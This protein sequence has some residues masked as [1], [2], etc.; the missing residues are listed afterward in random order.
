MSDHVGNQNVGFLMTRHI[1][2][3][4][5]ALLSYCHTLA[6][7]VRNHNQIRTLLLVKYDNIK[8]SGSSGDGFV[9]TYIGILETIE[10]LPQGHV[11]CVAAFRENDLDLCSLLF[12]GLQAVGTN[13]VA[14]LLLAG[15]Q[16]TR[17]GVNYPKGM[18]NVGLPSGKTLYQIQAERILKVQENAKKV[19]GKSC[20]VP[21]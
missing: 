20:V 11:Q 4:M 12:L 6:S 14:V 18:Y 21:W 5:E 15:G 10:A 13:G 9:D 7:R 19:M 8:V 1:L 2:H 3:F 17:L 16:G